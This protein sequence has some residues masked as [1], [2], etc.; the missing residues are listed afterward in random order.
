MVRMWVDR[1]SFRPYPPTSRRLPAGRDRRPQPALPAGIHRV[2]PG[3]P[4]SRR[5]STTASASASACRRGRHAR[6]SPG[7]AS[8]RRRQ[9]DDPADYRG[10][11]RDS[12]HGAVTA[13]LLRYC[14]QVILN[15]RADN[16]PALQAYRQLG[17]R[18]H[19]RFEERL[20]HRSVERRHPQVA[21]RPFRRILRTRVA[22]DPARADAADR[23]SSGPSTGTSGIIGA[24]PPSTRPI[25]TSAPGG[26]VPMTTRPP[27]RPTDVTDL[28]LADEGVQRISRP[29]ADAVLARLIRERFARERPLA[30][31]RIAACLHVATET[32]SRR[33]RSRRE[34]RRSRSRRATR[35]RRRRRRGGAHRRYGR[36]LRPRGEDRRRTT[37]TSGRSPT[38][39]PRITMDDGCDLVSLLHDT[40]INL[41]GRAGGDRGDDDGRRPPPGHGQRTRALRSRSSPWT[42]RTTA[43]LRHPLRDRPSTLDGWPASDNMLMTADG[44]PSR[45]TAGSGRGSPRA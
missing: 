17:Y 44:R 42:G 1:A 9:R 8:R 34:A 41:P 27:C 32:A 3:R 11:G 15:V 30:G 36:C 45:A 19:V 26:P 4:R 28:G 10:R 18:E 6:R 7:G 38:R 37:R 21:L 13:E 25:G 22:V 14:D 16:P 31:V 12:H 33:A 24:L 40:R 20:V 5:A 35:C 23:G 43:P 39:G 2:A 29:S